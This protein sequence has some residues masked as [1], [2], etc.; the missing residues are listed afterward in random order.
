VLADAAFTLQTG[1]AGFA[2]RRI[3]VCR[4]AA[5]A[6]AALRAGDAKRAPS[7]EQKL[8]APPVVFMFPGQGAQYP[9]MGAALYRQERVF[10]AEIDR[11]AEIL[12]PRLGADLRELMFADAASAEAREALMQTRVTQPA[13]FAIEYALAKL[14]MSWGVEPAAMIG[15][16]VGE[17]VA[18]CLAGV[19]SLDDA[20]AM[21]AHRGALVQAQPS[22][23]MLAVRLPE[24]EVAPFLSGQLAIAAINS[25]N[26]CVVSGP[27][28]EIAALEAT[29]KARD[30]AARH[31]QTSHAFHSPM[32]DPV[33][34]PVACIPF[35]DDGSGAAAVPRG[36]ASHPAAGAADPV[37]VD[38]HRHLDHRSAS[39][40]AGIL[41]EPRSR[42]R[43]FCRW[44]RATDAGRQPGA[45]RS[46]AGTNVGDAGAAAS[47]EVGRSASD[48]VAA[49]RR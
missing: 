9:G 22:G 28:D 48:R 6:A 38:G 37:G 7:F 5:D 34:P 1:R 17:Y 45:G 32:M 44:H 10:A 36:A 13:L 15:H 25:P 43:P 30:V 8:T 39:D 21:V 46:R 18:A 31:L 27:H 42:H 4:A 3:V 29:L 40:V 26:L 23:A 11:C 2:H 49:D 14:W 41:G 24:S 20:L 16:S 47:V 19:F 12:R 35:A 33:L